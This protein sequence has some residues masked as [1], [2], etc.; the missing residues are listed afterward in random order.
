MFVLTLLF[1]NVMGIFQLSNHLSLFHNL[2]AAFDSVDRN[3]FLGLS[4][5]ERFVLN[6]FEI[7]ILSLMVVFLSMLFDNLSSPR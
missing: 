5:S 7:S 2:K 1:S 3:A 6:S 4:T